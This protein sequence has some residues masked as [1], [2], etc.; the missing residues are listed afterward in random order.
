MCEALGQ[1]YGSSVSLSEVQLELQD[2]LEHLLQCALEQ[3]R[4]GHQGARSLIAVPCF[5]PCF[6][7]PVPPC[8]LGHVLDQH[9]F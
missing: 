7:L 9:R 5:V 6:V 3:A 8:Y 4:C 1:R 2:L